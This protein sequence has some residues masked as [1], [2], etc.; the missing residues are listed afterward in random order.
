MNKTFTVRDLKK[1]GCVHTPEFDFRDDG[2]NFKM[3]TYNGLPVCYTKVDGDY[4]LSIR[5]DY[6]NGLSFGDYKDF[7]TYRIADEF[8]A[9]SDIDSKVLAANLESCLQELKEWQSR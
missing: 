4:Y 5:F 1:L 8:N 6:V 2:T 9:V 3:F 7:A